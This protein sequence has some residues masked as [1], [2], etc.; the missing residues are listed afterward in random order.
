MKKTFYEKRGSRYLPVY[1]YD[2]ELLSSFNKGTHLVVCKPGST[3]T[4]YNI[5]PEFAPLIAAGMYAQSAIADAVVEASQLRPSQEPITEDQKRA[6]ESLAVAFGD[7]LATL[8]GPSANA[9]AQAAIEKMIEESKLLI[10]NDA[11]RRAYEHF[12]LVCKLTQETDNEQR[13]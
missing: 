6:W 4:K 5:D 11:V 7:K 9:V 3:M 12:L 2:N 10:K 8:N 13:N 1:E